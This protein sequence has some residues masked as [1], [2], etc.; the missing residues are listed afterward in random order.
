MK[1]KKLLITILAAASIFAISGCKN[2]SPSSSS[3]YDSNVDIFYTTYESGATTGVTYRS[4]SAYISM[5]G[6]TYSLGDLMP[7]WRQLSKNLEINISDACDYES[8]DYDVQ[9]KLVYSEAEGGRTFYYRN[10][11]IDIYANTYQNILSVSENGDA[12]CLSDY[13][14]DLPNFKAYLDSHPSL[15]EQIKTTDGK[16]YFI[17]YIEP[18]DSIEKTFNMNADMVYALLDAESPTYDTD[19]NLSDFYEPQLNYGTNEKISVTGTNSDKDEINVNIATNIISLQNSLTVKNGQNLTMTLRNY[20]NET[21]GDYVGSGKLYEKL[22]DIF[23]SKSA[24]YNADELIALMRCVKTNPIYLTG[25]SIINVF[26]PRTTNDASCIQSITEFAQIW[27]I[28]G[29]TSE[30]DYLYFDSEGILED[31]R[32]N[33][34]TYTALK[35][36]ND[37]YNEGLIVNDFYSNSTVKYS[38]ASFGGGNGFMTYDDFQTTSL[39]QNDDSNPLSLGDSQTNHI[40]PV[41]PP[42]TFWSNDNHDVYNFTRHIEDTY[43]VGDYAWCI[44]KDSDSIQSALKIFDYFFSEE[45]SALANYGPLAFTDGTEDVLGNTTYKV[46]TQIKENISESLYK[47]MTWYKVYVGSCQNLGYVS[48]INMKYQFALTNAQNGMT[49]INVAIDNG[50]VSCT[51]MDGEGF[52]KTVWKYYNKLTDLQVSNSKLYISKLVS[53][54]EP[55]VGEFEHNLVIKNGYATSSKTEEEILAGYSNLFITS[56]NEYLS[57][58]R[59]VLE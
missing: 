2:E 49:N 15:S 3:L 9:Q 50:V 29:L 28:S 54:W 24:C 55:Q 16:I 39:Y 13:F 26:F 11:M 10:R 44:P 46:S 25:D 30:K 42:V 47:Y 48:D 5:E 7:L 40:T 38:L 21:Y 23:L 53:F 4:S 35:L 14:N 58:Y 41:L 45:G 8:T 57:I 1:T 19:T 6:Y 36:L 56:N 12:L 20:L 43:T 31:A 37:L 33:L 17:P 51:T 59:N 52:N 34:A 32:T 22:S 27:G 18:V